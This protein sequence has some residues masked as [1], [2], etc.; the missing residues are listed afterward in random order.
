[1]FDATTILQV[2]KYVAQ[3]EKKGEEKGRERE[4]GRERNG[5]GKKGENELKV[6]R[7]ANQHNF[8]RDTSIKAAASARGIANDF[9]R[10]RS[11]KN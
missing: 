11:G 6:F 1:M 10:K 8:K 4:R 7:F 3:E 2:E 9:S 5:R